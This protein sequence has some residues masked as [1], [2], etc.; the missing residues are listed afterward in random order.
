[1]TAWLH[2]ILGSLFCK[3]GQSSRGLLSWLVEQGVWLQ[4]K[5]W[6]QMPWNG[7]WKSLAMMF[8]TGH[9]LPL[10]CLCEGKRYTNIWLPS[11]TALAHFLC[12]CGMDKQKLGWSRRDTNLH[13]ALLASF[14]LLGDLRAKELRHFHMEKE[15]GKAHGEVKQICLRCFRSRCDWRERE[16]FLQQE[17]ALCGPEGCEDVDVTEQPQ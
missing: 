2:F 12:H 4:A 10:H 8:F 3:P 17:L 16:N 1:M 7:P 15:K 11:H 6:Q 9:H 5:S 14:L 13:E